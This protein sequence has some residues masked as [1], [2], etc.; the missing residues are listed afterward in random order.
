M[1][2]TILAGA[3]LFFCLSVTG[4]LL[5][6]GDTKPSGEAEHLAQM[7]KH[8]QSLLKSRQAM[9][10]A[11]V[12]LPPDQQAEDLIEASMCVAE[13]EIKL[14]EGDPQAAIKALNAHLDRMRPLSERIAKPGSSGYVSPGH[15]LV[16]YN[17]AE[18]RWR[19]A[20]LTK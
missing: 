15:H 2:K 3:I 11:G 14:G 20:R 6:Q 5:A 19:I 1:R 8:A 12:A 13:T 17:L 9:F 4:L 16:E 7:H 10:E 18:T